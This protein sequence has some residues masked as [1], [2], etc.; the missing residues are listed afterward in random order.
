LRRTVV[1]SR[2]WVKELGHY[3]ISMG[4]SASRFGE[5][6]GLVRRSTQFCSGFSSCMQGHAH[7]ISHELCKVVTH[8]LGQRAGIISQEGFVWT[9]RYPCPANFQRQRVYDFATA[10]WLDLEGAMKSRGTHEHWNSHG[11]RIY[12][13]GMR[14]GCHAIYVS[15]L[16]RRTSTRYLGPPDYGLSMH[17]AP[18]PDES[19]LIGDGHNFCRMDATAL[20]DHHRPG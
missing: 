8:Q 16:E 1:L 13:H 2:R 12:S 15:D 11:R 3:G 6:G 14:Y 4:V 20:P 9:E 17:I 10:E 7:T 18:A 19:F 5:Y